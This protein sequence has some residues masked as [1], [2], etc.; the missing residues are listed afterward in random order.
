VR[1]PVA[2]R[3]WGGILLLLGALSAGAALR[4]WLSF[5]DD[6]IYWPDE[7]YQSLEPA[8]RLV[9]GYGLVPWEF[10]VG[11][12]NWALPGLLGGL[13]KVSAALGAQQ[14]THYLLVARLFFSA[15]SVGT[16]YGVYRLA[17]AHGSTS[18]GAAV[19]A[20]LFALSAPAI[21]FAPRALSENASAA[22]TVFGFACLLAPNARR[23]G[24]VLG[25]SLLG[26]AVLLRI[27]TAVFS[28]AAVAILLAR[29]DWRAVGLVSLV[30][31]GW[32]ILFGMLDRLTW[33]GWF[34]SAIAYAQANLMQ[35]KF[36]EWG[37]APLTYYPRVLWSSMPW[38]TIS[39]VVL[40]AV[41]ARR[42]RGLLL[43]TLA[44]L[45]FHTWFPHKEFRFILPALPLLC[46]TAG[47]GLPLLQARL[48]APFSAL[49]G[50]GSVA[51]AVI[52]A[53]GFHALTFGQLGQYENLKP[54]KSAYD[55]FGPVNRLLL[56]ANRQA[57]LCA[58]K[59]EAVHLAWTGGFSYLHRP[60]RLYSHLAPSRESGLYNYV[61]THSWRTNPGRVISSEAGFA[62]IRLPGEGCRPDPEY[63]WLLP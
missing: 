12:R 40:S 35:R 43:G 51:A 3:S 36:E 13:L 24:L 9:F 31:A 47:V 32:A 44:F 23:W 48:R 41:A 59:V 1:F 28:F 61:I 37:V 19:G 56:A 42:A 14:P 45:L 6:G 39:V 8:H 11:A 25:A 55:D 20:T 52:S 18:F 54:Q 62:L 27:H 33:G 49:V 38:T 46:A 50:A 7:I 53:L 34:H 22:A 10:V 4:I 15:L 5:H 63:H 58:L 26:A 17:Q 2:R 60:V 16:G 30:L 21:Y 29:R 57:D